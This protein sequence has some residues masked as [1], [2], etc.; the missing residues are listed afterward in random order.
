MFFQRHHLTRPKIVNQHFTQKGRKPWTTTTAK[1]TNKTKQ[2]TSQMTIQLTRKCIVFIQG[3]KHLPCRHC[4]ISLKSYQWLHGTWTMTLCG[5][6]GWLAC[7]KLY[8]TLDMCPFKTRPITYYTKSL[9]FAHWYTVKL[10]STNYIM[11]ISIRGESTCIKHFFCIIWQWHNF[12]L[13]VLANNFW[14]STY[15]Q[16]CS[17]LFFFT[18]SISFEW[19]LI[20]EKWTLYSQRF[21]SKITNTF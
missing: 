20:K 12:I 10:S 7:E 2:K 11:F 21:S 4:P 18:K 15:N 19:H 1:S 13:L 5:H 17:Y 3:G 6:W 16:S 9:I 8:E 14:K